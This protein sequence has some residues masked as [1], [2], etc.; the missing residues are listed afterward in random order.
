MA[1]VL[2]V[3]ASVVGSVAFWYFGGMFVRWMDKREGRVDRREV[4]KEVED[5]KRKK[6]PA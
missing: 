2:I 5:E 1:E 4:A 3:F 6:A